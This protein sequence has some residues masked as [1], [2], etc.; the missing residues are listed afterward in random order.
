V[1]YGV[2]GKQTKIV[3]ILKDVPVFVGDVGTV[4]PNGKSSFFATTF[5]VVENDDY[6]WILGIPLLSAIDG[7]VRCRERVL[8]YTPTEAST[9]ITIPLITR[10]QA[11]EQPVRMQFR[12]QS[13]HL[14][15]EM[16]EE[17]SWEAAALHQEEALYVGS[18]LTDILG[19]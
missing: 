5:L 8:S 9:P 14:E 1:L 3:A 13:P 19:R 12:L 7:V 15:S 11:R 18:G 4:A 16:I 2:G 17:A 6:H 10:N